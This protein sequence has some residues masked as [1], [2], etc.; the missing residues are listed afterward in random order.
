LFVSHALLVQ[1]AEACR[2]KI[3]SFNSM[4]ISGLQNFIDEAT[5]QNERFREE[6]AA[7]KKQIDELQKKFEEL[8]KK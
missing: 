7:I 3:P 1:A 4:L 2:F 8:K 5:R 6:S